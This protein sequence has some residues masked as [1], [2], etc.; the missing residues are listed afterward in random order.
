MTLVRGN[1]WIESPRYLFLALQRLHKF[2][3]LY[4][5]IPVTSNRLLCAWQV[6][7]LCQLGRRKSL[8]AELA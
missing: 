6:E 4:S 2:P 5:N 3:F 8:V 1:F 7:E